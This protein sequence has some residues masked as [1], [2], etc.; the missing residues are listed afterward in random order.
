MSTTTYPWGYNRTVR[1]IDYI[2]DTL[3]PH[4]HPEYLARLCAWLEAQEGHIGIGGHWRAT[5]PVDPDNPGRFAPPG[6]S[7]HQDQRY[8]DGF[9]GACAVDLVARNGGEKHRSPRW[10]EVPP[11]GSIDAQI[12]GVHCNIASEAWHMQPVEI[13]GW[14]T[15]VNAGSPAPRP[16]YPYP[17]RNQPTIPTQPPKEDVAKIN[18]LRIRLQDKEGKLYHDQLIALTIANTGQLH[19]LDADDDTLYVARVH[20]SRAELE[21]ELG[22]KLTPAT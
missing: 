19:Q 22:F 2:R 16:G 6:K 20:A 1:T 7:F 13:D 18:A 11:Q 10:T 14:Q 8:S 17:G 9:V 3:T 12:W 4:Y 15:W 21:A 5:Q